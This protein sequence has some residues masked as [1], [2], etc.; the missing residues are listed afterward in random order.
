MGSLF[1]IIGALFRSKPDICLKFYKGRSRHRQ[2]IAD[3][4][5]ISFSNAFIFTG[6][7]ILA[8]DLVSFLL[9]WYIGEL[10]LCIA[11]ILLMVIYI[12]YISYRIRKKYHSRTAK[13]R[14]MV[15]VTII[16]SAVFI[17]CFLMAQEFPIIINAEKN[18]IE[19]EGIYKDDIKISAIKEIELIDYTPRA[20]KEK[21]GFDFCGKIKGVFEVE[22]WGEARFVL[23]TPDLPFITIE[24][25]SGRKFLINSTNS[26]KTESYYQQIRKLMPQD[27]G[28]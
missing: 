3:S 4:F 8:G 1:I 18:S 26:E 28:Y 13:K 19:I 20:V 22:G 12:T 27:V 24:T 6:L 17:F 25:K 16:A 9:K 5:A 15:I 23:Q 10:W 7:F 14:Y 21:E 2:Q 11:P